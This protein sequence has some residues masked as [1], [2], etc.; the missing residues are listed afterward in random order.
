MSPELELT[1]EWF[2]HAREDLRGAE[3]ALADEPPVCRLVC[4]H[5]QQAVEKALKAF[6]IYQDVE[7]EWAHEI[8]Y[9][10]RLCETCN[11]AFARWRDSASPL[12]HYAVHLRYPFRGRIPTPEEARSAMDVARG[13]YGF[14][15]QR[16]PAEVNPEA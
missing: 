4:S 16:L 13:V 1:R 8:A 7:F 15:L 3:L 5:C 14:V 6:L 11:D 2:V 12:T 10:L 9:L